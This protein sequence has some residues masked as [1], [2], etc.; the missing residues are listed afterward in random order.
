MEPSKDCTLKFSD[1]WQETGSALDKNKLCLQCAVTEQRLKDI[2]VRMEMRSVV[3]KLIPA[4][5][6]VHITF[7]HWMLQSVLD[8]T[9][10][11]K[12]LFLSD[13]EAWCELS[14]FVTVQNTCHWGILS[15][16][17]QKEKECKNLL[18]DTHTGKVCWNL[19]AISSA[20]DRKISAPSVPWKSGSLR[21]WPP[22]IT[23][24]F[25][26]TQ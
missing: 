17:E 6:A 26:L 12:L 5:P 19:P 23:Q 13:A 22:R 18:Q 15:D 24:Y 14:G 11:V 3:Q 21:F 10:D 8:G 16:V 2:Q 25:L 4:D 9:A 7:C 20:L 1:K